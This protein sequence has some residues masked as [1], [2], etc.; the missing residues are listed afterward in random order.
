M[1]KLKLRKLL[2]LNNYEST[3]KSAF[4][5]ELFIDKILIINYFFVKVKIVIEEFV[6][7]EDLNLLENNNDFKEIINRKG[8]NAGKLIVVIILF[9]L[10]IGL[11]V[12]G[13]I[14]YKFNNSPKVLF[15]KTLSKYTLL[16]NDSNDL[17]NFLSKLKDGYTFSI[18]NNVKIKSDKEEIMNALVNIKLTNNFEKKL[19]NLN[20]N[21]DDNNGSVINFNSLMEE[22]RTY[23]KLNDIFD[24]YY[25]LDEDN[26]SLFEDSEIV[27]DSKLIEVVSNSFSS[28]FTDDKFSKENVD[29][30]VKITVGLSD[31]DFY[32]LINLIVNDLKNSKV[33]EVY[34]SKEFPIE[35]IYKGLDDF[36]SELKNEL[37]LESKDITY[38]YSIYEKNNKL[39]KQELSIRDILVAI[40]G[41][42][43]G[44]IYV[45]NEGKIV[46]TGNYNKNY[47]KLSYEEDGV[48]LNL[49]IDYKNN[50]S[51]SEFDSNYNIVLRINELTISDYVKLNINDNKEILEIDKENSKKIDDITAEEEEQIYNKL[52]EIPLISSYMNM[53]DNLNN[54]NDLNYDLN[55]EM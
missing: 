31:K 54:S 11:G 13:Y 49:S 16:K 34:A 47:F 29:D 9:L 1:K 36:L 23:L 52:F 45:Y 39:I 21:F 30:N 4:F 33:L 14:F 12:G 40:E 37:N 32:D 20:I 5:S 50:N 26:S 6:M 55:T 10:M 15:V 2:K 3:R 22:N 27:D 19:A 46:L 53:Y 17:I 35:D 41:D 48:N 38:S 25:Y 44:N 7:K 43:K 24:K 42:T 8:S 18:N 51:A 28:Y